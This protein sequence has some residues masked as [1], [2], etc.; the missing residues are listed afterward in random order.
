MVL[1]RV[2]E[3]RERFQDR[4]T[5]IGVHSGTYPT[6]RVTERIAE[7]CY[8]LGVEHARA[9]AAAKLSLPSVQPREAAG[10]HPRITVFDVS[11]STADSS[12]ADPNDVGN[13]CSDFRPES[14]W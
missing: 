13:V 8:R 6:E 1:P 11:Q 3:M 9:P 2:R 12:L 10:S 5:S 7:A 4:L 14:R